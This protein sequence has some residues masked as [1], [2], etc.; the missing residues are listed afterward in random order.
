MDYIKNV[1]VEEVRNFMYKKH[2]KH[3]DSVTGDFIPFVQQNGVGLYACER[4][5]FS[6]ISV[7]HYKE[8]RLMKDSGRVSMAECS[9][10]EIIKSRNLANHE[11]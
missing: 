6:N 4:Y 9:T 1:S 7:Y 11:K 3:R 5:F 10:I 2:G 8:V